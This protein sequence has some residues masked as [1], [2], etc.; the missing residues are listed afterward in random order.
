[1]ASKVQSTS[2]NPVN[3]ADGVVPISFGSLPSTG[4]AVIVAFQGYQSGITLSSNAVT[5]NQ[6][7]TY[8]RATAWVQSSDYGVGIYHCLNVTGSTGTFTVT[9]T[10]GGTGVCQGILTVLEFSGLSSFDGA[11]ST[12]SGLGSPTVTYAVVGSGAVQVGACLANASQ[13][14]ITV[15][16]LSPA[17]T[18]EAE[19]LSVSYMPGEIDSRIADIGSGNFT[20]AWTPSS[21]AAVWAAAVAV[22]S[23]ASTGVASTL[24]QIATYHARMRA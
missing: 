5:D 18:E 10:G 20:A 17:W 23:A 13:S 3:D 21:A 22:Y 6:G 4:N 15:D 19:Q 2:I 7:N 1:M 24:P 14:S 9:L 11:A 16:T 12:G 8:T